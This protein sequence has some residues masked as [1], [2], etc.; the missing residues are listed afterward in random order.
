MS[1]Y[2]QW[3]TVTV[4]ITP[5]TV[6]DAINL[7]LDYEYINIILP[8]LDPTTTIAVQ[9]GTDPTNSGTITYQ[10]L[11]IGSAAVTA[12]TTGAVDTTLQIGGYQ[13]I[14]LVLGTAQAAARTIYV[15]G[16]RN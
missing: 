11:G 5:A 3:Q 16:Y 15:R 9:I 13:H 14:K 2:G 6:S 7:G 1:I 8:T 4:A 12:T 10:A